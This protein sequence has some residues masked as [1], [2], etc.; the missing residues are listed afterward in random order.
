MWQSNHPQAHHH[1]AGVYE[2]VLQ[3]KALLRIIIVIFHRGLLFILKE[4]FQTHRVSDV[5][6]VNDAESAVIGF[7]SN[8][9]VVWFEGTGDGT[10]GD[11][12]VIDAAG[13]DGNA[14]TGKLLRP[15]DVGDLD[16][17]G[18][19]D[20]VSL[21]F[22]GVNVYHND[23]IGGFSLVNTF[24][25]VSTRVD[26]WL[27]IADFNGDGLQDLLQYNVWNNRL[28]LHEGTGGGVEYNH[29]T[30][31]VASGNA[32]NAAGG[33]HP[34]D[35][36]RD[37]D[38]DIAFGVSGSNQVS[39]LIGINDG[40]GDFTV[41]EYA[42]VDFSG[43]VNPNQSSTIVRGVMFGDYNNDGV[44]DFS[45]FT[46]SGDFD[47][48]GIRLGTRPGEFGSSRGFPWV[49]G[50]RSEVAVPLDFDADGDIDLVD[51]I[52]DLSFENLGDGSFADPIPASGQRGGSQASATAD[53]NLDGL[54]D[55]V[56][57]G[58]PGYYVAI[59]NGDGTFTVVPEDYGN[60]NNR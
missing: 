19:L 12:Q 44:T 57:Q 5:E 25:P 23:G 10:F 60:F 33:F 14:N 39:T 2:L 38:L 3:D 58:G 52:N 18:D 34:T 20:F 8:Y 24:R 46:Q 26:D 6:K 55:Y 42:A 48:V 53:F 47:G 59:S 36:D 50:A 4:Y 54:A 22:S 35:I 16:G 1:L 56:A 45:Y 49:S 11:P 28:E 51:S 21:T 41:I 7:G 37:G 29:R 15:Y 17:D 13:S 9:E 31:G 43:S 30:V 27:R 32:G 40:N